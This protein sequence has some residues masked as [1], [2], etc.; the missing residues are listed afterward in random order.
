MVIQFIRISLKKT[1]VPEEYGEKLI[2][3]VQGHKYD[4]VEDK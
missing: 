2:D 4:I 1:K 3:L